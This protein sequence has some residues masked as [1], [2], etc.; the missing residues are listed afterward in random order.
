MHCP[1]VTQLNVA[2]EPT[3]PHVEKIFAYGT[4]HRMLRMEYRS[5]KGSDALIDMI[6]GLRDASVGQP[7]GFKE[8][9]I[10]IMLDVARLDQRVSF[11][12]NNNHP[13]YVIA[14][15]RHKGT[16]Y[17]IRLVRSAVDWLAENGW[18]DLKKMEAGTRGWQSHMGATDKLRDFFEETIMTG[19]D[20]VLDT[21]AVHLIELR[22]DD[23]NAI[24]ET[25]WGIGGR[26]V[27]KINSRA[28]QIKKLNKFIKNFD[29]RD[30]DHNKLHVHWRSVFNGDFDH[31]GRLYTV[32]R[33][34][35]TMPSIMRRNIR[36]NGEATVELDYKTIHP[37]ML[38]ARVGSVAPADC[39]SF[40]DYSRDI[41]KVAFQI[42]LNATSREAAVKALAMGDEVKDKVSRLGL[43][44]H[45]KEA[46][47]A[48]S[49]LV[50][51]I[52]AY[53]GPIKEF[54]F[55]GEGLR[56]QKTDSDMALDV[57]LEL[58]KQGIP[59]L[60]VHD[61]FRVPV[62]KREALQ[63]AMDN[64][65]REHLGVVLQVTCDT[66]PKPV[67][68]AVA[69]AA[70]NARSHETWEDLLEYMN[71]PDD[72]PSKAGVWTRVDRSSVVLPEGVEY[73]PSEAEFHGGRAY[74]ARVGKPVK[75]GKNKGKRKLVYFHSA[76]AAA[77]ELQSMK[78]KEAAR[79][80]YEQKLHQSKTNAA[81]FS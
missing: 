55:T 42:V 51:K 20:L 73:R 30:G 79:L 44:A 12:L 33:S 58:M 80:A 39:Y 6:P 1:S 70:E 32:G 22:D 29:V 47:A 24:P 16:L 18:I 48:A 60:S 41:N 9:V 45:T 74:A 57:M 43:P 72:Q 46:R 76:D 36:I 11:S 67:P 66:D 13:S 52:T 64:A 19:G 71:A 21:D 49:V 14:K 75:T 34:Y 23:K 68:D 35:Q 50:E 15:I 56:L 69:I 2:Y 25:E 81:L 54:F 37:A 63:T 40:S 27:R 3:K 31:G 4:R 7:K 62:S 17:K 38:Y 65:S 26:L 77:S 53:H 8:S 28:A 61:S 10:L 5:L 78:A 59:A